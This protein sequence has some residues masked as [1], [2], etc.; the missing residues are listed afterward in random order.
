MRLTLDARADFGASL[1][2]TFLRRQLGRGVLGIGSGYETEGEP[3]KKDAESRQI[4]R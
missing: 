4:A 1:E 2:A 3:N